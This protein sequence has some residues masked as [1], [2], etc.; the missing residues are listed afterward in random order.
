VLSALIGWL[1]RR[2]HRNGELV[3]GVEDFARFRGTLTA[4]NGGKR[5]QER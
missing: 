1:L 3:A 4:L 5:G 2:V